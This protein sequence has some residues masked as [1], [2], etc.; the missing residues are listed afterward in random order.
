VWLEREGEPDYL[1]LAGT[2]FREEVDDEEVELDLDAIL[3]MYRD[4]DSIGSD[5]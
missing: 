1:F 3:N 4:D 2:C 5:D